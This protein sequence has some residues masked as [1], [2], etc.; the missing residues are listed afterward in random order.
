MAANSLLLIAWFFPPDGGA[1]SQRPASF[2]RH[3][4]ALGW[5]IDVITRGDLHDRGRWDVHDRSYMLDGV[6]GVEIHRVD[7]SR[8]GVAADAIP[9]LP[10]AAQDLGRLVLEQVAE[11]DPDVVLITMSPFF[12]SA[13]IEP[14]RRISDARIVV[15]LRDPWTLD[16]WPVYRSRSRYIE[17]SR[18][19]GKTLGQVD[20]VVFNTP[21]ALE[22]C[23]ESFPRSIEGSAPNTFTVIENGFDAADFPGDPGSAGGETLEVVHTGTFHC[24]Y[25]DRSMIRRLRRLRHHSRA[26]IDRT[27]RT[28]HHLLE[29]ARELS[30]RSADFDRDVRFRFIGHRDDALVSCIRKSGLEEK[31]RLDGYMPHDEAVQAMRRAGALF[32]PG[33]SIPDG[34]CDLIVPGKTYEYLASGRPILAALSPGDARNLMNEA[35]ATYVCDPCDMTLMI[36]QLGRLHAD[37]KAGRLAGPGLRDREV[38]D[39]YERTVLSERLSRYLRSVL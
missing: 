14:I 23:R 38:V 10:A 31:V 13:L 28:P 11:S 12:L 17:E 32:L 24:E 18:L 37:W 22:D 26:P 27:G 21:A 20:G 19:M 39:R 36:E 6:E 7:N 3:L 33:G 4:P 1:G 15:D 8:N 16:Y 2:A 9:G 29:A 30:R 35:G 34:R 5:D 25:L